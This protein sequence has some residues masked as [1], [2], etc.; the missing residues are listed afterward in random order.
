VEAEV[1]PLSPLSAAAR[2]MLEAGSRVEPPSAEQS[3]RM[4]RTLAPLFESVGGPLPGAAVQAPRGS[5]AP[6]RLLLGGSGKLLLAIGAIAASNGASFWFGRVSSRVEQ[7]APQAA[8]AP[9]PVAPPLPAA[10]PAALAAAGL[11][12]AG[13]AP[14][15][16]APA[17]L[18]PSEQEAALPPPAGAKSVAS[19]TTPTAPRAH[20]PAIPRGAGLRADIQRLSRADAQLREGKP[21]DALRLLG[22]PVVRELREQATALRA[23]AGCTLA[24]SKASE[25]GVAAAE[26]DAQAMLERFPDSPYE[27]RVRSAC[28]R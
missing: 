27:A 4:A 1:K 21:S 12:P 11:A 24:A 7:V 18:A 5:M 19:S 16:L 15:G 20:S 3:E 10:L 25:A 26:R 14:A 6:S 17:A 9:A 13:L 8:A 2:E 23:V 22:A 28:E